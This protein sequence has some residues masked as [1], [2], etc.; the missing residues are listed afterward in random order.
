MR[1]IGV[2]R[3]RESEGEGENWKRRGRE[4][5]RQ[6]D[7]QVEREGKSER[8]EKWKGNEGREGYSR[9]VKKR[10]KRRQIGRLREGEGKKEEN[11]EGEKRDL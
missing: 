8:N 1:K 3:R 5:D 6:S 9:G 2:G 4:V 10:R 11:V 7:G